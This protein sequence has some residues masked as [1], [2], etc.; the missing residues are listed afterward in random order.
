M[1]VN[2]S[3]LNEAWAWWMEKSKENGDRLAL[4]LSYIPVRHY[5]LNQDTILKF[6]PLE[7][8]SVLLDSSVEVAS[9]NVD[10]VNS[11]GKAVG[12]GHEKARLH[13]DERARAVGDNRISRGGAAVAIQAARQIDRH[14][15]S[16]GPVDGLDGNVIRRLRV[17]GRA[18]SQERIDD[19]V[20][21]SQ[22]R[23]ELIDVDVFADDGVV[24]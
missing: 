16:C 7:L 11:A 15:L 1:G 23:Q 13:R 4:F 5:G 19:P 24:D 21:G 17:A 6:P 3:A 20:G 9:A 18:G 2:W 10:H 8:L 14:H 22:A 12:A